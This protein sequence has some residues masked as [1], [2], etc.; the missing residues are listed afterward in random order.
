MI[1]GKRINL[2]LM[3]ESDLD[4]ID[5][6]RSVLKDRGLYESLNLAPEI[7]L[8]KKFFDNGFW[9]NDFGKMMVTDKNENLVGDI[10]FF[11]GIRGCAGYEIGYQ[12][13]KPYRGKG[14]ATEALKLFSSYLFE[15]K[16]INRLEI[17]IFEGNTPSRKVAEKCGFVYEGKMRQAYF[18]RGKYYNLEF[19]SLLKEESHGLEE[20]IKEL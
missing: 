18:A 17:C 3:K 7:S 5:E 13:F 2:R 16:P 10:M 19:F 11:E 12:I 4:K 8:K 1:E 14:Y 6:M 20:V 15:L 9:Q